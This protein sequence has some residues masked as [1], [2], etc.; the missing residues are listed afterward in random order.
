LMNK[1]VMTSRN[2]DNNETRLSQGANNL[3]AHYG[4]ESR[5]HAARDTVT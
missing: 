2:A 4:G 5:A 3:A 1:P